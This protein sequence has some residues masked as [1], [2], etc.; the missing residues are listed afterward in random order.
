MR[1]IP[2]QSRRVPVHDGPGRHVV[3][4]HAAG[5]DQRMWADGDTGQD[6]RSR[7]DRRPLP[8]VDRS[9]RPSADCL[10]KD[11]V[12]E[13]DVRADE[14]FV[15]QHD[16]RAKKRVR[17]D[18]AAFSDDR[19]ADFDEGGTAPHLPGLDANAVALVVLAFQVAA[20]DKCLQQLVNG[21]NC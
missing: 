12:R 19:S 10:R 15:F 13:A 4:D 5:P 21:A 18:F 9:W 7:A 6:H 16:A 3:G 14:D 11:V 17:L 20:P 8:D 2:R 1:P